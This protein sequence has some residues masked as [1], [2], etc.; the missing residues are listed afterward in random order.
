MADMRL[1]EACGMEF[2]WA[3]V[4]RGTQEYCCAGCAEGK[5]CTCPQHRHEYST[6]QPMNR[7]AA[8][9]LGLTES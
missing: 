3:G 4:Q 2:D 1:C 6:D 8:G 5:E 7:A 9:Q